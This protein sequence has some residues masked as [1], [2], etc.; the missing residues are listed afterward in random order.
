[1]AEALAE[2]LRRFPTREVTLP[3][4]ELDGE[5]KTVR[6]FLTSRESKA[7]NR[8]YINE[9]VW[10]PT[11][12]RVGVIS[13]DRPTKRTM[14]R[15]NQ[16]TR[17]YGMHALRHYFASVLLDAGASIKALVE[18]L[19]HQDPGFTLRTYT[20]LM[21]ASDAGATRES[22]V[23][24][25]PRGEGQTWCRLLVT[26]KVNARRRCR[27]PYSTKTPP[28]GWRG[29]RGDGVGDDGLT[30]PYPPVSARYPRMLSPMPPMPMRPP[31]PTP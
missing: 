22:E 20:H 25:Q 12:E 1:M 16:A 29:R 2:H 8:S 27:W 13:K 24:S 4:E 14:G 23:V 18:Y 21:P 17:E 9:F 26:E 30:P 7:L 10:K 15:A 11:F 28:P 6:L 31:I 5:S 19:G 3:R